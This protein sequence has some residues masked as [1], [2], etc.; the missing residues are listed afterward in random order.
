MRRT[1]PFH[2]RLR[3]VD[4]EDMALN[5]FPL[6]ES[7]SQRALCFLKSDGVRRR[8]PDLRQEDLG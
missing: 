6:E 5:R 2:D 8:E 4:T 1:R 7:A 3:S